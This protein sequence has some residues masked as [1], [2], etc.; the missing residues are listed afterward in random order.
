MPSPYDRG[1]YSVIGSSYT[2]PHPSSAAVSEKRDNPAKRDLIVGIGFT[3]RGSMHKT[4]E[5][6][7]RIFGPI[8]F[9]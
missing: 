5:S 1:F 8:I 6:N 2:I 3:V 4:N 7:P 9:M